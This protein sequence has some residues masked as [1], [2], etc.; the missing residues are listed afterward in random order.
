M[1]TVSENEGV[2]AERQVGGCEIYIEDVF[3]ALINGGRRA[4]YMASLSAPN[5]ACL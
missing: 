3:E 4:T 1:A 2:D 5:I